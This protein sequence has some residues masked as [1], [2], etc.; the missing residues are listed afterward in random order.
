MELNK[1][2]FYFDYENMIYNVYE[3][4]TKD[5]GLVLIDKEMISRQNHVISYLIKKIGGSLIKGKSLMNVS[6][7]VTI[8]DKRTLLQV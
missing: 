6:L 1:I 3:K 5:P 7:P 4:T 8:F 2:E